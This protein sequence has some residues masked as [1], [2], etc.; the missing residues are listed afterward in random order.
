MSKLSIQ[1]GEPEVY[2]PG[3][4]T[5]GM[6]NLPPDR[7][8][9]TVFF[10]RQFELRGKEQ[11]LSYVDVVTLRVPVLVPEDTE[12]L[13]YIARIRGAGSKTRGARIALVAA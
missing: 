12:L 7:S 13:G 1:W 5:P 8:A 10:D 3:I 11:P 2:Q 6:I 9:L 4:F